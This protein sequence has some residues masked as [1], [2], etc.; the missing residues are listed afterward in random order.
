MKKDKLILFI[1]FLIFLSCTN[2][3]ELHSSN[4][5]DDKL[6]LLEED[7]FEWFAGLKLKPQADVNYLATEDPIIKSLILKHGVTIRLAMPPGPRSTPGLLLYYTL[8]GKYS[9][10]QESRESC[11]KAF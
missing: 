5:E 4:E 6:E 9:M 7:R 2:A 3:G 10:S 8:I 1:C 11:V